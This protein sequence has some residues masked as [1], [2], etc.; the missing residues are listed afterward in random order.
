M[1]DGSGGVLYLALDTQEAGTIFVTVMILCRAVG[2]V[3]VKERYLK[4]G[5][6]GCCFPR[7]KVVVVNIGIKEPRELLMNDVSMLCP[8]ASL[9][10]HPG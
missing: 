9:W 5:Q 4:H 7:R 2:S 1:T 8:C 3:T 6:E 10:A